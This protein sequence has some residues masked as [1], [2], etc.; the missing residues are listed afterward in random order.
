MGKIAF[1]FSGQGSQYPGMGRELRDCSEAAR[2]VF[3]R[4][5]LVRP[6][7]SSQCFEGPEEELL[8]TAVTQP[9]MFTMELAAA[10][11]L[12][13]RGVSPDFAAGFSLGE[14]AALTCAGCFTLETG[15]RIVERRGQ[16]MQRES[17]KR[18][19]AMAAVLKLSD[20]EVEK[21]AAMFSEVYPVNYNCPG[22]LAVA[23]PQEELDRFCAA[24]REAGGRAV[25]LK[26]SGAFHSPF[27]AEAAVGFKALLS[28]T[29]FLTPSVPVYSD[30]TGRPYEGNARG[31]LAD[32]I[33]SPV[34]WQSIVEHMVE[35]GADTF[36]ELGPGKTL[37]GLIA[38]INK[39]VRT[40]HVEDAASLEEAV[41]EALR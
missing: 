26:V 32:Q 12:S 20:G 29:E 8:Q 17:L 38:R 30:V 19:T 2:S 13:E 7:T 4:A 39:S 1:V 33:M 16:L 18:R 28:Q 15:L 6:G 31:L 9:C 27:M 41:R 10:A 40:A 3:E 36:I 23:G 11:A 21:L 25:P 37:C 14:L 35:S 34:R 5:D 22:Q 24:V